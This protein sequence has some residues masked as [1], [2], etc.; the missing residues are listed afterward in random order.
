ME[1]I[2]LREYGELPEID[3]RAPFKAVLAVEDTVSDERRREIADW[4]VAMGG[5][6]MMI[7]GRDCAGWQDSIR[8]ANLAR[9]AIDDMQPQ[10]FVMITMHVHEKLRA[11]FR[12]AKSHAR[13]THVK[14]DNLLT[15]HVANRNREVEYR[16]LFAKR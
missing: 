13:H 5:L 16:N 7:C 11:V 1:Y 8:R 3:N 12:Y 9:V 6:Y 14:I 15:I 2:Q 10:Q 4:L